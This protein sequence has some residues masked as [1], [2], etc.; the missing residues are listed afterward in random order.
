MGSTI[1]FWDIL[2]ERLAFTTLD[3]NCTV[4]D[5][6]LG[7]LSCDA[8]CG[9]R[10]SKSKLKL[11]YR[12]FM[13]LFGHILLA[14]G[15]NT[16]FKV[17]FLATFLHVRLILTSGRKPKHALLSLGKT[18]VSHFKVTISWDYVVVEVFIKKSVT[19]YV[20]LYN[21]WETKLSW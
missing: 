5:L 4:H 15:L 16:C 14:P 20:W 11:S 1:G 3:E 2:D 18:V 19:T 13:D 6:N 17:E 12:L 10:E 7:K 21:Q 8:M 9:V